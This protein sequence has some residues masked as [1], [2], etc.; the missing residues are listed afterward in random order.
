ML[1]EPVRIGGHPSLSLSLSCQAQFSDVASI[2]RHA[3]AVDRGSAAAIEPAEAAVADARRLSVADID[4]SGIEDPGPPGRRTFVQGGTIAVELMPGESFMFEGQRV[5]QGAEGTQ[6]WVGT[7][8]GG[9]GYLVL[10]R[11]H[12]RMAG[13][14]NAGGRRFEFMGAASGR[15]VIREMFPETGGDC[16]QDDVDVSTKAIGVVPTPTLAKATTNLSSTTIDVLITYSDEAASYYGLSNMATKVG[17]LVAAMNQSF[18][19]GGVDGFVR[20][21]G[22][23][24]L[25]NSN[26]TNSQNQPEP[27]RDALEQGESPFGGVGMSCFLCVG[28]FLNLS[29]CRSAW[30][31]GEAVAV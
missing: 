9:D 27:L 14:A 4:L 5:E 15:I 30:C 22:Y 11:K 2:V 12:G 17:T 31:E 21:V 16:G 25:A 6:S 8:R 3:R 7:E 19:D 23:Q 24:R 29:S 28:R 18:S 26:G 20:V 13:A 10:T 1:T